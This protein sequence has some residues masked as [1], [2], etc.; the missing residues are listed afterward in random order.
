MNY[1]I[2][3]QEKVKLDGITFF[4]TNITHFSSNMDRLIYIRHTTIQEMHE[5]LEETNQFAEEVNYDQ[6]HFIQLPEFPRKISIANIIHKIRKQKE[7]TML[8]RLNK[9]FTLLLAK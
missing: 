5:K 3:I 4:K 6:L 9:Y 2:L 8:E 1:K 7:T